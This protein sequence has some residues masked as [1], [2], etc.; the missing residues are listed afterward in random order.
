MIIYLMHMRILEFKLVKNIEYFLF[1]VVLLLGLI[2]TF[3]IPPFQK[4][5]EN[6]HFLRA[7]ALSKGEFFCHSDESG[8]KSFTIPLKYSDYI[9]E[10]GTHR[11]A[12]KYDEKFNIDSI[13]KAEI[14]QQ[15]NTGDYE[16]KGYCT[17]PFFS[18]LP[19]ALAVLIG[20]LLNSVSL[21]FYLGRFI[22]FLIFFV[23]L[24]WS[25]KK[26]RKSNLRW[27]IIAFGLIPM[28]THQAS[29]IGYDFLQLA[30]IPIIF[31][32]V[33][34]SIESKNLGK[35]DQIFFFTSMVLLLLAKPGYYFMSLI[36]FLIPKDKISRDKKKYI[37]FSIIYFVVCLVIAVSFASIY[38]GTGVFSKE[39][40][41]IDQIKNLSNPVFFILLIRNTVTGS[42]L[43]YLQSFIG[44][45]GWLDYSLPMTVYLLYFI[46]WAVL[47]GKI[48][49]ETFF[50]KLYSRTFWL[51]LVIIMTTSFIFGSIYLTWN[52]VGSTAIS[53][54]QGRYFLVLFPFIILFLTGLLR[55]IESK[56][57]L[58]YIFITLMSLYLILEVSY[59]IYKRYYDY[60]FG[61]GDTY[62]NMQ[63]R[64]ISAKESE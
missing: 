63:K 4:P 37:I 12:F 16:L 52:V 49:N 61:T 41:P 15:E 3:I 8:N 46:S 10:V 56:R 24:V 39:I 22:S 47:I 55:I 59:G 44:W 43:F 25:Y 20:E 34:S 51:G 38:K 13:I 9:T 19:T 62:I 53:G 42:L 57:I 26:I 6:M 40:S 7:V 64:L 23:F 5:D 58:L 32:L 35:K 31:A 60:S 2:F 18:Y 27:V 17:L 48:K 33:I 14:S 45:F 54:V 1:G 50:N 11:I 28:V 29:A 30:T 36:F 21:S